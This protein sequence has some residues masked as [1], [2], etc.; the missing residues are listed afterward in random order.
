MIDQVAEDVF[1]EKGAHGRLSGRHDDRAAARRAD[2]PARS[3]RAPN[4]SRFGTNDLTQ[5]TFGLSRDDAGQL[6]RRLMSTRASIEHDPFVSLDSDGVGELI[7][8]RR[9]ARPR[10]AAR[11]QARHLR[12]ARR[13]PGLDRASARRSASITSPARPTAC[14]SPGWRPRRRRWPP[15]QAKARN[16]RVDAR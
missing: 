5:T 12:R 9:R 11:A 7:E 3:P 2:A 4:S 8:H 1:A 13:R 10:G 16:A 14:R 15:K 6:P